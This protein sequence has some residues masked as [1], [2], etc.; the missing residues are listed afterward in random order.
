M[1][2]ELRVNKINGPQTFIPRHLHTKIKVNMPGISAN[3]FEVQPFLKLNK[4]KLFSQTIFAASF[5]EI[6]QIVSNVYLA[7]KFSP[8]LQISI[9]TVHFMNSNDHSPF[10]TI[11]STFCNI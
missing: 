10:R 6:L 7:R 3:F 2:F 5:L 1:G 11:F 4:R 8:D 9:V